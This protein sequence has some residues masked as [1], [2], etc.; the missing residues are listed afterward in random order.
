[1]GE[2]SKMIEQQYYTRERKGIFSKTPGYDTV[3]KSEG[4]KD[5]F[6]VNT[7]HNLCFYD[8]PASLAGEQ[9]MLKYPK[10]LFYAN[11]EEG[12]M[13]IGQS[14]FAGKDY[15]GKRTR[16]FTHCYVISKE[17]RNKYIE[18]P[19]KIIYST[20]FV[21]NYNIENGNYIPK[22]SEIK[23]DKF[24]DCFNSIE[25]MFSSVSINRKIFTNMIKACFDA[26]KFNKKIYIVLDC[27]DNIAETAK[28]ILKYLYRAL[29]FEVRRKIGFI[30]YVKQPEL[31]DLMNI[32]FLYRGSIKR[33]TTDIKAGYV[34]DLSKKDFYI[35]GID[36]EDHIFIEYAMDNIENKEI[37]NEFFHNADNICG[38]DALTIDEYDNILAPVEENE[39]AKGKHLCGDRHSYVQDE[40]LEN[41]SVVQ[42]G[43]E[44]KRKLSFLFRN[45]LGI[46]KKK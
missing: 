20:G 18:N 9:D 7:L 32:E 29:P 45:L 30:T 11:T 25:D 12:K 17:E 15:T 46:F 37:L 26:A 44:N 42:Q 35:D 6:I 8:A 5:E 36:V 21:E 4:L 40:D 39:E 23:N 27:E 34:F 28:G 14:V 2:E 3:A 16:Y 22:A 19:E 13:I 10:A 1:M 24:E 43:A 31:K 41:L 33:L 38:E